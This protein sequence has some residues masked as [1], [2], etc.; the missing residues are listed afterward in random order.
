MP[1]AYVAWRAGTTNRVVVPPRQTGN[2]FLGSL[3]GLQ[4][5]ALV[6][7]SSIQIV[8]ALTLYCDCNAAQALIRTYFR[9]HTVE[10]RCARLHL[11]GKVKF[12]I[13]KYTLKNFIFISPFI[14]ILHSIFVI[15]V[16]KK[17]LLTF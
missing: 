8:Y 2:R 14:Y 11:H 1:R 5:P 9:R 17:F 16:H 15:I 13:F 7:A 3:G 4:I 6:S 10:T 12:T